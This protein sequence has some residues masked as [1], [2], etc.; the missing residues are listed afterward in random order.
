LA[1]LGLEDVDEII[2]RVRKVMNDIRDVDVD[3]SALDNEMGRGVE[4]LR[5]TMKRLHPELNDEALDALEWKFSWD[6]RKPC[7]E[8]RS[9]RTRSADR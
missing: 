1:A 5:L 9:L 3:W 7:D 8:G 2:G 6:W 4:H